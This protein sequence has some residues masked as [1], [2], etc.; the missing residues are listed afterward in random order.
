M[1]RVFRSEAL[2]LGLVAPLRAVLG[3]A[4]RLL[5]AEPDP[6]RL[7][8]ADAAPGADT[9]P[10]QSADSRVP[11]GLSPST[12]LRTGLSKPGGDHRAPAFPQAQGE[13]GEQRP[14]TASGPYE[15][16]PG[17]EALIPAV[18]PAAAPTPAATPRATAARIVGTS[19]GT[20]VAAPSVPTA[21]SAPVALAAAAP[22]PARAP[23]AGRLVP[24]SVQARFLAPPPREAPLPVRAPVTPS[25]AV[26]VTAASETAAERS[27]AGSGVPLYSQ[28]TAAATSPGA[29]AGFP[30]RALQAPMEPPAAEGA[31]HASAAPA[32]P[33]ANS[34]IQS[35]PPAGAPA[36]AAGG[37]GRPLAGPARLDT[38]ES[39]APSMVREVIASVPTGVPLRAHPVPAVA[40]VPSHVAGASVDAPLAHPAAAS[41]L[42][43]PRAIPLGLPIGA[44][45]PLR[46]RASQAAATAFS[47]WA[48]APA[49]RPV[50]AAAE[51]L[52]PAGVASAAQ[53]LAAALDPTLERAQALSRAQ[54]VPQAGGAVNNV[55][56]VSVALQGGASA[57]APDAQALEQA[58][59]ELLLAAARRHGLEL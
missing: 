41:A 59:T 8:G 17:G 14:A 50:P 5:D 19:A 57:P 7:P 34:Q 56:N 35:L 15:A 39:A 44:G 6:R 22:A 29:A 12:E 36:V 3:D 47:P 54:A 43:A 49:S 48:A 42:Q 28:A 40:A 33:F 24:M 38:P 55:F 45:V 32:G 10:T 31:A 11:F 18:V 1:D 46:P 52:P 58:L 4:Q 2:S 23:R 37:P 21:V 16:T 30:L 53:R 25:E 9:D 27:A 13:R 51:S 26:V 20:A